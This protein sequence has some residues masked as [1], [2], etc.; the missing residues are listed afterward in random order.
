MHIRS[1][2]TAWNEIVLKHHLIH[3]GFWLSK[4]FE[5]FYSLTLKREENLNLIHEGKEKKN[6]N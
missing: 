4:K 2:V 6:D 3:S 1:S 5:D